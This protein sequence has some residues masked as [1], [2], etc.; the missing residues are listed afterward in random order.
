MNWSSVARTPVLGSVLLL[1]FL[2]S[3]GGAA[4]APGDEVLSVFLSSGGPA[5]VIKGATIRKDGSVLHGPIG[6]AAQCP[7][8]LVEADLGKLEEALKESRDVLFFAWSTWGDQAGGDVAEVSFLLPEP[9]EVGA[10]R[11]I[12][13]PI[14][15]FPVRLVRLAEVVDGLVSKACSGTEWGIIKHVER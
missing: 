8:S 5:P 7:A 4:A 1:G 15:L 10:G 9:P 11:E 14:E 12:G 13:I 2:T 6:A 3:V